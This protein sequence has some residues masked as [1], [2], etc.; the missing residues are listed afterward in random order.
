MAYTQVKP[1][2]LGRVRAARKENTPQQ[3]GLL[4][5]TIARS[6]RP[7]TPLSPWATRSSVTATFNSKRARKESTLRLASSRPRAVLNALQE[8]GR[9]PT[10]FSTTGSARCAR[11][12][13]FRKRQGYKQ[14]SNVL[15]DALPVATRTNM[16]RLTTRFAK[17]ALLITFRCLAQWS[18]GSAPTA[19]FQTKTRLHAKAAL[20]GNSSVWTQHSRRV[21]RAP[22]AA[23]RSRP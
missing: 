4:R 10:V 3:L 14:T 21:I 13:A 2:Q 8:S 5:A 11:E 16:A 15:V 1:A 23:L 12:D 19:R 17:N 18:A 7:I 6:A 22:K 20:P 9:T